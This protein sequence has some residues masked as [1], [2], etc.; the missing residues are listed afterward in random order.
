M[1]LKWI[2]MNGNKVYL[3]PPVIKSLVASYFWMTPDEML[4]DR[5][6]K[7]IKAKHIAIFCSRKFTD[8]S[9]SKIGCEFNVGHCDVLHAIKSVNNQADVYPIYRNELN[10]IISK[11][12]N[13][14][15]ADFDR[16]R[17]YDTEKV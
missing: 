12:N 16:M 3:Q 15:D 14:A 1:K 13:K 7:H 10:M 2:N 17:N 9:L 4:L 11:L 6:R 5:S 8:L